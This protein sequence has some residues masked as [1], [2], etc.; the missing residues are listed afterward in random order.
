MDR[1]I[2][3]YLD[4]FVADQQNLVPWEKEELELLSVVPGEIFHNKGLNR[5]VEGTITNIYE[6]KVFNFAFKEYFTKKYRA[7]LVAVSSKHQ[8]VYQ[9]ENKSLLDYI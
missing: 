5:R 7:F 8:F 2:N 3:E 1:E 9:L 6:E 4:E